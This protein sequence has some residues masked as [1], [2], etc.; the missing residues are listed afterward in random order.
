MGLQMTDPLIST[1]ELAARFGEPGLRIVDASWYLPGT[2]RDPKAEFL[3]RHIPGAVF[4]DLDGVCDHTSGLP[5]TLARPDDFAAAVGALGIG[6]GDMV[7]VYAGDGPVS[8][9]RVWWN[10]RV[11]GHDRVRVLDGGLPKWI[12]EDRPLQSGA[13]TPTPAT[14][15]ARPRPELVRD[16]HAVKAALESGAAQVVDVRAAGRFRGESP[17]PR[18]GLRAGHMPGATNLP[19]SS[20]LAADG[21]MLGETELA[22]R[23]GEAELDPDRPIVA[24]CG[25]GV[26]ACVAALALARMGKWDAAVYDGSWVEWGGRADAPVVTGA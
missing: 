9:S 14:F 10:F 12:A 19:H 1:A 7:V 11:M 13:A 20:L 22:A 16:F 5:H 18:P 17:E 4:F 25:S 23:F 21:Q 2:P 8:A 26:S 24:S 6:D 15:V 3:E